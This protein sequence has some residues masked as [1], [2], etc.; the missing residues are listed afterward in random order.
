MVI[1]LDFDDV[2]LD[3]HKAFYDYHNPL[4][5]TNLCREQMTTYHIEDILGIPRSE[6]EERIVNF[7]HSDHHDNADPVPGAYEAVRKLCT[8]NH[9]VIITSRPDHIKERTLSWLERH[10]GG[11]F[12]H[13]Y[14]T[15]QFVGRDGVKKTKSEACTELGVE[16]FVDDNHAYAV[17]VANGGK[18]ALLF[19]A[20]WNR[21]ADP[22]PNITRVH[23]W[24]HILEVLT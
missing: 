11:L 16:V 1:G 8:N 14:F 23:S 13:V 9:C 18:K 15:N 24:D 20:P 6:L 3:F 21:L 5:G 4:Y 19:D 7:Y 2:L 12:K 10:F 17:D 22:H